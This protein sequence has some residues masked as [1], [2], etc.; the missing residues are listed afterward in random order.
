MSVGVDAISRQ[1][2]DSTGVKVMNLA[3]GA[4][5]SAVTLVQTEESDE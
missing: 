5:L 1:R 4:E 3:D 2:R